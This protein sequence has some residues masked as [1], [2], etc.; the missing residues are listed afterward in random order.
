MKKEF[1]LSCFGCEHLRE[2]P[3]RTMLCAYGGSPRKV[4][5]IDPLVSNRDCIHL[6]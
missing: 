3:D 2:L 1:P 5:M 4:N 6:K